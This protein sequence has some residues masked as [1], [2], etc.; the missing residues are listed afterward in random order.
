MTNKEIND[1]CGVFGILDTAGKRDDTARLTYLGLFA[2]QHSGQDAAG[3]AINTNGTLFCHKD[4]GL[5]VEAFNEMTLNMLRGSAAIGHV[6]YPT[7]GGLGIE[8][9]QPMLIKY[10][11]GQL[12]LAHNGSLTNAEELHN[13]QIGRASWRERV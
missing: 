2:L 4:A 8:C 11:G 7:Q 5:V 10:H 3:I 9:A 12:A 1:E 13:R 6:R